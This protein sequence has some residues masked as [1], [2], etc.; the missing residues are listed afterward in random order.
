MPRILSCLICLHLLLL[1]LTA[2]SPAFAETRY[3][4]DQLVIVLRATPDEDAKN[5]A[6]LRTGTALEIL[7]EKPPYAKVRTEKNEEGYVKTQYLTSELPKGKIIIRL[8]EEQTRLVNQVK[9]LEKTLAQCSEEL[10]IEKE[11]KNSQI[12]ALSVGSTELQ[13]DLARVQ[14]EL[15]K[16]TEKYDNLVEQ[17]K[18]VIETATERD[19]FKEENATLATELE[20]LRTR[21][22]NM[23]A[24][25]LIKWFLA[26]AGVFLA[27][28]IAGKIS[29][30]K[31]HSF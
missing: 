30:K 5:I 24:A 29:K 3:V 14:Q 31:K 27:G 20:E 22:S 13:D 7:Q 4:T 15:L 11:K 8:K 6:P 28:W 9:E 21:N 17:S 16:T 1:C 19:R 18:R 23:L 10:Q 25:G 26:G 2:Q 12:Q